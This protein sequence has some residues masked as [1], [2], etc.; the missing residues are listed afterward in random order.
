MNEA[1]VDFREIGTSRTGGM[2]HRGARRA[3]WTDNAAGGTRP[4]ALGDTALSWEGH[5]LSVERCGLVVCS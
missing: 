3:G 2:I 1:R 4:T 5:C